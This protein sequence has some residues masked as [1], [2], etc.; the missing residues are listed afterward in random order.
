ML[1]HKASFLHTCV[2]LWHMFFFSY[3]A[4]ILFSRKIIQII[5]L[6]YEY[7]L[8]RISIYCIIKYIGLINI[9]LIVGLLQD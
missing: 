7:A 8:K 9:F 3:L 1:T 6:T 4:L 2:Y 5:F